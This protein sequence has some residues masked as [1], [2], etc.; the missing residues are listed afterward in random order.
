MEAPGTTPESG[1]NCSRSVFDSSVKVGA[2]DEE[3]VYHREVAFVLTVLGA[4]RFHVISE[5]A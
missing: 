4:D 3:F 1:E 5:E 2:R